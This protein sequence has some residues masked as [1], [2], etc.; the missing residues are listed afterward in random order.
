MNDDEQERANDQ[1]GQQFARRILRGTF[2]LGRFTL[3]RYGIDGID[4]I[5]LV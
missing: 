3:F 2:E 1:Q 5:V 4:P